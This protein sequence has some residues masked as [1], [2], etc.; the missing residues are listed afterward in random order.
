MT[1]NMYEI[2][3]KSNGVVCI[4]V[5]TSVTGSGYGYVDLHA[6]YE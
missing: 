3:N 4:Y 6:N 2:N 5:T 1:N